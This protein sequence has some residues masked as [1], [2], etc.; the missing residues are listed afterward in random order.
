MHWGNEWT[1]ST[2]K[3]VHGY[4]D[5]ITWLW[6]FSYRSLG[7]SKYIC[8][9][10]LSLT[11]ANKWVADIWPYLIWLLFFVFSNAEII[12]RVRLLVMLTVSHIKQKYKYYIDRKN[13]FV[14]HVTCN[15]AVISQSI[16]RSPFLL[17]DIVH[18]LRCQAVFVPTLLC[19]ISRHALLCGFT[20]QRAPWT[21]TLSFC[22]WRTSSAFCL[23]GFSSCVPHVFRQSWNW[24]TK[25]IR[26]NERCTCD[27]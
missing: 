10:H 6:N 2:K 24:K 27:K 19:F 11:T 9:T 7:S 16:T 18:A 22:L 21:F 1:Q 20:W 3:N 14:E 5:V 17:L 25:G 15:A 12:L 13:S 4:F 26:Y 23:Q 8:V